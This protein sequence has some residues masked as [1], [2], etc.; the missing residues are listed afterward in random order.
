MTEI[1]S[2]KRFIDPKKLTLQQADELSKQIGKM[3]AEI[4]D[5][6]NKKCNEI[7]N[8]YGLQTKIG[9]NIVQV[10]K[11]TEEKKEIKKD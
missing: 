4:M 10:P 7:L 9:Y 3:V 2:R 11:K 6:A 1:R 8:I 5:D